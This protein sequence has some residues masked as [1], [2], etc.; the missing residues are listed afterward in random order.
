MML[1]YRLSIACSTA[2]LFVACTAGAQVADRD[3]YVPTTMSAE[4]QQAL[5]TIIDAKP[6]KRSINSLV[7]IYFKSSTRVPAESDVNVLSFHR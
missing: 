2:L 7:A 5:K 1:S 6:Y 3:I 4:G